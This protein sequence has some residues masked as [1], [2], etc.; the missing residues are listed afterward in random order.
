MARPPLV[1]T[2]PVSSPSRRAIQRF[3]VSVT[4]GPGS[5]ASWHEPQERCAIG[6]H[7][8]NDLVIED[9]TVSRFHCELVIV[10]NAVRV[11]DL[12]SRNGTVLAGARIADATVAN[13]TTL[14][15]GNSQIRIRIDPDQAEL[16]ASERS[17]FGSL[18]GESLVMREVFSQLE[19][20]AASD[21]TVLIEGETG[22]GKEGT[23]EA[24]HEAGPRAD[25]P[26]IVVDCSAISPG[27]V[28]SELFGH[29]AGAFTGAHAR[30]VGA[31]ELASGGT[32][33]LDEIGELPAEIQPKLLRALETGEIRRVG[34][35]VPIQCDL[36]IIAATNRD[37]REE[38]NRGALRP[39]LY[40]R[41]AVVRIAL[42]PLRE[43]LGEM[44]LL[45]AHFL[46]RIGATPSITAELTDPDYVAA[47]AA[48]PWPGNLRELRNHLEQCAVFGERR[49]PNTPSTPHPSTIVDATQ[50]YE[51][52]RRQALDAFERAYLMS[53]LE[54]CGDSVAAAA[55][56]AGVNR[57]YLY[58]LLKRHGM[59]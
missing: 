40:F 54:L 41:L 23:A 2:R 43:R 13:D 10:G 59:R 47:L 38:V 58:R 28:E 16:A 12:G 6:S 32:L 27:V 53:C 31:F 21:A 37:L 11:R 1:L 39:D 25:R 57:T 50:P 9:G 24:I 20:I 45:V 18:V 26:F 36:R 46:E 7:Q 19:K 22:T 4:A 52:A 56:S 42:P 34:G 5:G 15:L 49:L 55:Q 8:S 14:A 29:E 48:A 35:S 33:F 30:R 51:I 44:P 3:G 17:M